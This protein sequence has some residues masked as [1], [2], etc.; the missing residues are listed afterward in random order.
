M[1]SQ[2]LILKLAVLA[3]LLILRADRSTSSL[4]DCEILS[5]LT[6]QK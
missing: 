2:L 6:G 3:A 4:R 1:F 5:T